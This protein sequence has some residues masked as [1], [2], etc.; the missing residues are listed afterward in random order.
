MGVFERLLE[1]DAQFCEKLEPHLK[2][3][4]RQY[5]ARD[6]Y[7]LYPDD[8]K[9]AEAQSVSLSGGWWLGTNSSASKKRNQIQIA[10]RVAG[11]EFGKDL[12]VKLGE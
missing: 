6:R 10:C 5:L 4:K 8:P 11:I 7:A 2:G 12:I 9:L 3:R 1:K